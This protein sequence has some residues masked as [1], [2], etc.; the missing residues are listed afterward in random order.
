MSAEITAAYLYFNAVLR[1]GEML[2]IAKFSLYSNLGTK[3]ILNSAEV[4]DKNHKH[5]NISNAQRRSR[6]N[7]FVNIAE[8][9]LTLIQHYEFSPLHYDQ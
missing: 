7:V 2:N 5:K 8:F 3:G 1:C 4:I 9:S 6:K